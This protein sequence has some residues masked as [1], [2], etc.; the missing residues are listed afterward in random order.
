MSN[1]RYP[2]T[3]TGHKRL[4]EE[5]E[6]L[7][8]NQRPEVIDAIAVA[9]DHGDLKENAEYHAARE[10]Q[11]F[12]EGRILELDAKIG[13]AQV[14]DPKSL[15]GDKVVFASTVTVVDEDTEEEK[16][17]KIVGEDE[18][19]VKEGLMSFTSPISRALIG[20]AVGDSVDVQAPKGVQTY[21]ILSVKFE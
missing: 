9:R 18:A 7:K 20:K 3:V 1:E 4:V 2:M 10:R 13:R 16:T 12:I 11:S 14:I 5:L 21:E 6:D 17:F 8:K 15:S 19:N